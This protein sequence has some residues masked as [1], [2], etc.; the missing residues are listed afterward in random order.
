M[1][2]GPS[3]LCE[4]LFKDT[5]NFFAILRRWSNF[6]SFILLWASSPLLL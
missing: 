4:Q 1:D 6:C 3:R 2:E 5:S